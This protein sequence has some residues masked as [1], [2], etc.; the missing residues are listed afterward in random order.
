L[1]KFYWLISLLLVLNPWSA[2]ADQDEYLDKA[3]QVVCA[4]ARG[5]GFQIDSATVVTAKHVVQDCETV[6]LLSNS[7]DVLFSSSILESK[8]HDLAYIRVS[9]PLVTT[10]SF[11]DTPAKGSDVYAVG[12]PIEGLVL[13]KGK[14][15]GTRQ[16]GNEDWLV[17]NIPA[18]HGNSG[19][20]VYSKEGLIGILISKD[21]ETGEIYALTSNQISADFV[22]LNSPATTGQT[23]GPFTN[24]NRTLLI[25]V[26]VSA[27]MTFVVGLG[28]GYFLGKGRRIRRNSKRRIRIEV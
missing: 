6:K 5:A 25:Q 16:R 4:S 2:N 9:K 7:N 20:P 14:L 12:A 22:N 1:K 18:D 15:N 21:E 13:S 3:I 24:L 10:S 26:I 11:A 8:S 23:F 19:G 28:L 27:S 17:L